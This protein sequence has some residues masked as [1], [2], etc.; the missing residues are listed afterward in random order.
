MKLPHWPRR[1]VIAIIMA[2]I[3]LALLI[4]QMVR[5]G[6]ITGGPRKITRTEFLMS[7]VVESVAYTENAK[8]GEQALSA[9]YEEA[10]RL[11][12]MLDR[13]R[14]G[15]DVAAINAQAGQQPVS[16]TEETFSIIRLALDVGRITG[17]AFDITVAPLLELWGFGTGETRVPTPQE[18][19]EVLPLVDFTKVRIDEEARRV[20]LEGEG[21]QLDLGGI[22]KGYIVDQAIDVLRQKGITSASVD[23]GGD[24]RV[25]GEK[26]DGSPWRIGIRNPRERRELVA[27]IELRDQAIVTSGDYERFFMHE[28]ERYHHIL[29]PDTG[30]PARGVISVTI[31]ANDAFTADAYSTAVFVLGLER[32]LALVE[33]MPGVDAIIITDDEQ[34]HLSSGLEGKVKSP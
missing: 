22:A 30:L 1:M 26:P 6:G 18:L 3:L 27:V 5:P 2:Q 20:F 11:E 7:T 29:D 16:V 28:G 31:V 33:S 13:H 17:G 24:I 21:I 12:A 15:S 25:I 14:A 9:A 8:D 10:A 4:V 19:A 34:M 23:A 32:G